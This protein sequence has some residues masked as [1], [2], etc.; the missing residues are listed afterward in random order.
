MKRIYVLLPFLFLMSASVFSSP[1]IWEHRFG[2]ELPL[3]TGT[4][5]EHE[6]VNLSFSFPFP[7]GNNI[8]QHTT[9]LVGNNGCVKL[10]SLGNVLAIGYEHYLY[11]N[12]FIASDAPSICFN[13]DFDNS[14]NGTVHFNDL[15]YKA[16]FTWNEVASHAYD[17]SLSSFQ[18]QLFATGVIYISFN[19]IVDG[20]GENLHDNQESGL[21]VGITPGN[22]TPSVDQPRSDMSNYFHQA[23]S[24]L[25]ER[26]CWDANVCGF[27]GQ[28][29]G[30]PGPNNLEFD[31]DFST[32]TFHPDNQGYYVNDVIF[33]NAF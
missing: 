23:N 15:G 14:V 7:D 5:D 21:V 26:W 18:I 3:I 19:G 17:N 27:D 33:A 6:T 22:L 32:L 24:T 16:I 11:F 20:P 31:L 25:F 30:L 10:G 29:D 12:Q 8:V 4:D 28:N 1:L 2:N 13:A 9:V